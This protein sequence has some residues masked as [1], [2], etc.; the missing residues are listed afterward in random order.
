MNGDFDDIRN[1]QNS[2]ADYDSEGSDESALS[3]DSE[4]DFELPEPTTL[5]SMRNAIAATSYAKY[6]SDF[7]AEVKGNTVTFASLPATV[8]DEGNRA[9]LLAMGLEREDEAMQHQNDLE[10]IDLLR[11]RRLFELQR[12]R[13]EQVQQARRQIRDIQIKSTLTEELLGTF[14][15]HSRQNLHIHL[16]TRTAEVLQTVGEVRRFERTDYDPNKPDWTKF[17]QQVEMKVVMLR[18]LKDKIAAG[19][20]VILVSSG[21][22]WVAALCGGTTAVNFL[23]LP[24]AQFTQRNPIRIS[25]RPVRYVK[26]GVARPF[27][28][29]TVRQRAS[30]RHRLSYLHLLPSQRSIRP[31]WLC[32]NWFY[33]HRPRNMRGLRL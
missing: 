3:Q 26:G 6:L 12:R 8:I 15:D 27:L 5:T 2:V 22:S 1:V 29:N 31:T 4:D 7:D 20:Y 13:A 30:R 28:F 19:R 14:F 21:T 24:L 25:V 17:E 32:S 10:H 18:G 23:P 11:K 16:T 33:Y 9:Q